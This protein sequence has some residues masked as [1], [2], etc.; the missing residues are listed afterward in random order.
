MRSIIGLGLAAIGVVSVAIGAVSA[1]AA[2][3][4]KIVYHSKL[5]GRNNEIMVVSAAGGAPTRLTRHRASDSNP[6][7]SADGKKIAFESNRR[8][9]HRYEDSDVYVMKADGTGVRELTFSNAF[10]G[11]PAWS[12]D[13][14]I[15]FESE[16]TG[17]SEIWAIDADG[18]NEQQLTSSPAFDGDPSWSPNGARIAFTSERDNGD[19]EIYV[20]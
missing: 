6:T 4:D 12:L 20:M 5:P 14:R 18:E 10:D 2:S 1:P 11:D 13:D 16:R 8:G 15:V 3:T 17:D 9:T 19:R 7:W